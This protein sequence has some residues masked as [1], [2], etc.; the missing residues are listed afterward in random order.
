MS[1]TMRSVP[2]FDKLSIGVA[3]DLIYQELLPACEAKGVRL[4]PEGHDV[5]NSGNYEQLKQDQT[6]FDV[7][8]VQ[9][10]FAAVDF[11]YQPAS[12]YQSIQKPLFECHPQGGYVSGG[13]L[14][15][16]MILKGYT[17]RFAK[18]GEPLKLRAEFKVKN[19]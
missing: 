19:L 8:R 4:I 5:Y 7:A 11:I 18:I 2:N 1:V 6:I 17:A 13:E 3:T 10:A 12:R 15:A 14:M 9:R 16:A